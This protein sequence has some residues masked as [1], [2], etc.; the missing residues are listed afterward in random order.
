MKPIIMDMKDMSDSTEVYESRPNPFLIYFI[1][2]LAG[3]F[4]IALIWM[5][6]S[7]IDIVVKSNGMFK[8]D[9][10][11]YDVSS[12]MTGKVV[13]VNV[14]DGQ[15]V[16]EGDVLYTLEVTSLGETIEYYQSEFDNVNARLDM[17]QAYISYLDGD[18]G[19]LDSF[20][21]NVYYKEIL[22]RKELL[23]L[24]KDASTG[25]KTEIASYEE[26]I[27]V[28]ENSIMQYEGKIDKLNQVNACIVSRNNTFSS[29]DSYY[30]SL[31]DSYN[32][33]YNL[34]VNQYDK[35]ISEYDKML[36]D[37]N[38]QENKGAFKAE[39]SE[40]TAKIESL[41]FEKE[42][43]LKNLELQQVASVEQQIESVRDTII[44]LKS[45]LS[46][47]KSQLKVVNDADSDDTKQAYVLNEKNAVLS[48]I[49]T[50]QAKKDEYENYLKKYDIQDNNCNIKA[51]KSGYFYLQQDIKDGAYI[52]EGISLGV[53]YSDVLVGF[54]AQLYVANSDIAKIKEG[55]KVKF[56]IAAY[57][58]SE[59]GYFTGE[60]T[61]IPKDITVDKTT[62]V[63]Y[64]VVE[65]S[66]DNKTLKSKN[67][68]E[69]TLMNGMACQGKIIVDQENVLEYL[70]R[71]IDLLD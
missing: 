53:I 67:G 56:E 38:K 20:V 42:Q 65:V 26:N 51:A 70:L 14:K 46:A 6:F 13:A 3:M 41:K 62:G 12:S 21:N 27:S 7:K 59:Y 68:D 23:D 15:F 35:S 64:Y 60:I 43:A 4:A 16:N 34:S 55:Q 1:Y 49:L 69:A 11:I 30:K 8:S 29:D 47:A 22:N 17:L 57:P 50:Y 44:S 36:E 19:A 32:S 28:L 25:N 9:D 71:K 40:I 61:N 10:D 24:N 58:S 52:Q 5:A 45:N 63:A 66:C 2:F 31:V 37:Y 54:T 33:N 39:I 18:E 48:E